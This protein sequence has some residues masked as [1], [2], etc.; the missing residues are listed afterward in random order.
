VPRKPNPPTEVVESAQLPVQQI[1]D[2][3]NLMARVEQEFSAQEREATMLAGQRI[4]RRQAFEGLIKLLTVTDIQD[5]SRIKETKQYKGLRISDPDGKLVT[6]TSWSDYCRLVEGRSQEAIDLD[7]KNLDRLGPECFETL[8]VAG[9]GAGRMRDLRGLPSDELTALVEAAKDADKET[10]LDLAEE[11]IVKQKLDKQKL[12]DELQEARADLE[13][14]EQRITKLSDDL[15]K[16]HEKLSKAQRKWKSATPDERQKILQHAVADAE[17]A[18]IADLGNAKNGLR[19]AVI[20]L[21]EHCHEEGLECGE[22]LGD[23]FG[24]LLNAVRMVRDD[25]RA[26][27]VPIVHDQGED[28]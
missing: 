19:A 24:R 9:I 28:A 23:T 18:I 15:N 10:V 12:Q 27:V 8:R 11:L 16:E 4:G 21:A 26:G 17:A 3:Q 5:L 25:E 13:A 6:V 1:N 14:K 7:I 2:A 22:F 20:A